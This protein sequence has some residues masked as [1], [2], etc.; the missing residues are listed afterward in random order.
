MNFI[1]LIAYFTTGIKSLF[2]LC[3]KHSRTLDR[4]SK[5]Q[6]VIGDKLTLVSTGAWRAK[7]C[8]HSSVFVQVGSRA[9]VI[10][11]AAQLRLNHKP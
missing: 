7:H 8:N 11:M 1:M 5:N 4:V 2:L 6:K 3:D 9:C 10:S